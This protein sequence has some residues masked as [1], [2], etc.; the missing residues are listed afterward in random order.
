MPNERTV[1][2]TTTARLRR[3]VE[4]E[5][6]RRN[7]TDQEA[8]R[9]AKLPANVFRALRHGHRPSLDRAEQLL[10]ALGLQ[11]RLGETGADVDGEPG[12]GGSE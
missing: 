2:R 1:N 4:A 12:D 8:A 10:V 6:Q 9:E 5:L 3:L 11:M 7:V